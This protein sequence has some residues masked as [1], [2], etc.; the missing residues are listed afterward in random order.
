MDIQVKSI[1]HNFILNNIR[2][3]LNLLM[4]MILFPYVSRVLGPDSLGKVEFAN[5]I[6]FY[7]VLFT[8]LGIPT[9]GVREIARTRDDKK[10]YSKVVYELSIILI[11]TCIVGY[12]VYFGVICSIS[13]LGAEFAL[14]L[15]I[16]PNIFLTDFSYEW[17]F[18]G[19]EN[20]SYIT[21][22]YVLVKLVQVALIFLLVKDAGQ[23]VLYAGIL[24]GV[25]GVATLFNIV[26]IRRYLTPVPVGSLEFKRHVKPILIIFASVVAVSVYTH[27]DVTMIGLMVDVEAVG[28]YVT[29]N[30]IVR[31]IS[32]GVTALGAVMIPR[33][34]NSL[35][36][37]NE[38]KYLHL[39][40]KSLSFSLLFCVPVFFGVIIVSEDLIL[41]FAGKQFEPSIFS[42]RLL[43]PILLFIPLAHFV[44]LQILYP[45]R[46]E[47]RYTIS[48]AVA[49]V[50][51]VMFNCFAIPRLEQN[52]A[53]LGT[54]VA[55]LVGVGIQMVFGWKI[56]KQTELFSWNTG[57]ILMVGMVMFGV[58]WLLSEIISISSIFL[59]L[60]FKIGIGMLV[61]GIGL[62]IV[63][64]KM[65]GIEINKRIGNRLKK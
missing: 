11:G 15:A 53:I 26:H 56:V 27:V 7:F 55:E 49:A 40:N 13:R 25:N 50:V 21:K 45:K 4:P 29:A 3:V 65:I 8:S 2:L 62:I 5:S 60:L 35:A 57:K 18:Q 44:G 12:L 37:K 22:R 39:L 52:G 19:V 34:E 51:N 30:R 20:Q 23:Y 48:V 46:M 6:V 1:K 14:F 54:C 17:F 9:Y 58:L 16:A 24:I 28:L 32:Q 61:Y 31:L 59:N 47:S 36:N 64:E 42:L 63:R 38:D 41:L 43:S 10:A 33:L